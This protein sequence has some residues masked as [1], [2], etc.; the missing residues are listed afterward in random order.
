MTSPPKNAIS[1]QPPPVFEAEFIAGL[2]QLFEE[3]VFNLT[4][5][6]KITA[7]EPH[8][9]RARITMR[10]ELVG[11]YSFNR[12]HGGVISAGLDAVDGL[13]VMAA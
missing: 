4:L 5:G 13:A 8:Q 9:V 7:I 11:H 12:V 3:K 1:P 2:K 10:P 6:L